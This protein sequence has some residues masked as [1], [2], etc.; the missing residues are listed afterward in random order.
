MPA[1]RILAFMD[2]VSSFL[3][4]T[5]VCVSQ[6]TSVSAVKIKRTCVWDTS[7]VMEVPASEESK[8]MPAFAQETQ[9]E[10]SASE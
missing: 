6:D 2:P 9:P 8:N 1:S 10:R 3:K 4:V 7:A 5:S